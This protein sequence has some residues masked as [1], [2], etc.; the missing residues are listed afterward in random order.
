MKSLKQAFEE[1]AILKR[2]GART[3]PPENEN[4]ELRNREKT[5]LNRLT[6]LIAANR[7][8]RKYRPITA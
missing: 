2:K 6:E 3:Q 7:L 5:L 8:T 4:L 1:I